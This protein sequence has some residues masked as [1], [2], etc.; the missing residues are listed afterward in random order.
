MSGVEGVILASSGSKML[1]TFYAPDGEARR[2]AV[3]LLHGL[4]G[5]EK[6]LDL[7][8]H[9][10]RSGI[11]CLAIYFR[12]AW[13][14]E[15]DFHMDHLIPDTLAALDWLDRR[16]G[17]D[18]GRLGLIGYS[19]GGWVALEAAA[20]DPRV[21]AVAA[22]APLLDGAAIEIPDGLAQESAR[23][24]RGAAAEALAAQW[25]SLPSIA[26][27]VAALSAKP[28]LLATA[29]RDTTFPP[30]HYSALVGQIPTLE[31]VRFPEADHSF[32]S[33]RPG[34]CHTIAQ[35]LLVVLDSTWEYPVHPEDPR[36]VRSV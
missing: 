5:T 21:H 10:R 20:L 29:D 18:P 32:V 12:G 36:S 4:P 16:A 19:L 28:I 9:L 11:G 25:R 26:R 17:V 27:R 3:A 31:W 13:G 6:N 35:W 33:V 24:L 34:L 7:A 15:G 2:P 23:V 14:S 30:A 8:H 1:G 22:L